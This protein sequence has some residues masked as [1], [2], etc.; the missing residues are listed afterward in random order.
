M[1]SPLTSFKVVVARCITFRLLSVPFYVVYWC[2][3]LFM[4]NDLGILNYSPN[5]TVRHLYC[6]LTV[7]PLSRVLSECPKTCTE[8]T[9]YVCRVCVQHCSSSSMLDNGAWHAK[10][11][12]N[13]MD[14]TEILI[15]TIVHVYMRWQTC[16][17]RTH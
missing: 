11:L 10:M 13:N 17:C 4:I 7:L 14:G 2:T 9:I 1:C 3:K 5:C 12:L 15:C 6:S 16:N 8:Q